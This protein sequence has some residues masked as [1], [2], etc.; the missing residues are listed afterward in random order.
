MAN[1][2]SNRAY[3]SAIKDFPLT[4]LDLSPWALLNIVAPCLKNMRT[5]STWWIG[6]S[7]KGKSPVAYAIANSISAYYTELDQPETEDRPH[8]TFKTGSNLDY[9]RDARGQRT[10]PYVL[11]DA[12][13]HTCLMDG[14]KNFME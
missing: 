5:N 3:A 11:D 7:G 9:F 14:L 6:D 10:M 4:L 2:A 8:P 13:T 1:L 12:R